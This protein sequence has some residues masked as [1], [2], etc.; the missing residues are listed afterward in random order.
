M[1]IGIKTNKSLVVDTSY[2]WKLGTRDDNGYP[3]LEY[4][5][6]F[7]RLESMYVMIFYLLVC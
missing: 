7:T 4:P 6:D 1:W 2:G 5:T 3:K